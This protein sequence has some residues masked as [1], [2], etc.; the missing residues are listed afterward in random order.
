M[1]FAPA[2]AALSLALAVSSSVGTAKEREPDPRAASLI[3]QGR[4]SLAAGE[5]QPA[6]DAFEAALAVDPGY[7]PVFLELANVARREGLQ[8]KAIRFYRELLTRDPGNL[9][10]IAG[11]GSALVEK[12]AVEKARSNLAKLESLCGANCAETRSLQASIAAGA[13]PRMAAETSKDADA[14]KN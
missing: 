14:A 1:R 2:A 7:S 13:R 8:G 3:A 5:I 9:A 10:A 6:I 11:E 12:G 4:A